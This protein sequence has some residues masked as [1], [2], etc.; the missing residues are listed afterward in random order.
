MPPRAFWD[1]RLW[2]RPNSCI[3]SASFLVL[4]LVNEGVLA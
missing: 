3:A 2:P 4:V 1:W